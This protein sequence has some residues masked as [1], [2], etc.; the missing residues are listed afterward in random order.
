M[1]R[2]GAFLQRWGPVLAYMVLIYLL[3]AQPADNGIIPH[4]GA[5][6]FP[7]RKLVHFLEYALLARLFLR[8]VR[9]S[10]PLDRKHLV[11]ALALTVLYACTDEYHQTF[12]LGRAGRGFDV[13]I[14]SAG[15]LVA[16]AL[17]ARFRHGFR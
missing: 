15:A 7:V 9:G 17:K 14:D 5:V 3:S 2:L 16:L 13:L 12:V 8:A 4:F 10:A 6:D 11:W 1:N